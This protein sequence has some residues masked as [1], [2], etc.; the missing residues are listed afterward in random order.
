MNAGIATDLNNAVMSDNFLADSYNMMWDGTLRKIYGEKIIQTIGGYPSGGVTYAASFIEWNSTTYLVAAVLDSTTVKFY[1]S[2]V[3]GDVWSDFAQ[4]TSPST[5]TWSTGQIPKIVAFGDVLA[6]CDKTGTQ[7]PLVFYYSSGVC[8]QTIEAYDTRTRG[9]ADW[10]AGQ[11]DA[12]ETHKWLD[13]TADAQDTTATGDFALATANVTSDGFYVAGVVTFNKVIVK[14]AEQFTGSPVATYQYYQ[15]NSTWADL[16]MVTTPTWTAATGDKTIEFNIP[17]DWEQW[18]GED[19]YSGGSAVE[20]SLVGRY[21]IRVSF[22]TA[23]TNTPSADYLQVYHTQYLSLIMAGEKPKTIAVHGNRLYLGSGSAMNYSPYGSITGWEEYYVEYFDDGGAEI[24]NIVSHGTALLVL[25]PSATY[26]MLGKSY[27]DFTI[28]KLSPLGAIFNN[29]GSVSNGDYTFFLTPDR[30]VGVT[31]GSNVFNITK[32][33]YSKLADI[34]DYD[35]VGTV[36]QVYMSRGF[37]WLINAS[38]YGFV[39][40]PDTVD[41][42][43]DGDGVAAFYPVKINVR[44]MVENPFAYNDGR[45]YGMSGAVLYEMD[46][47]GV[48]DNSTSYF[49]TKD[50]D[51]DSPTTT[52]IYKRLKVRASSLVGASV[53]Q[54]PDSEPETIYTGGKVQ[55]NSITSQAVQTV[56]GDTTLGSAV[57]SNIAVATLAN[58]R[59]GDSINDTTRFYG[60]AKIIA[61]NY[62][63]GT[64][65]MNQ[66]A[67]VNSTDIAYSVYPGIKDYSMSCHYNTSGYT[68]GTKITGPSQAVPFE[69]EVLSYDLSVRR[70]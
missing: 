55:T 52:K 6:C 59:I 60:G 44:E 24:S 32:H 36:S 21:V 50:Y 57:I 47:Y 10:Y 26:A 3:S 39:V 70:F 25:K 18:D 67:R 11:Y 1:S 9:D 45:I 14:D 5:I 23:P 69:V 65:T 43:E 7:K 19:A 17:T 20:G 8:N 27:E 46:A 28:K 48:H 34:S 2:Y 68:L 61:I 56:T 16:S 42:N 30:H 22:S 41:T 63:T 12:S 29:R 51:F 54:I 64:M 4:I 58:V 38:G 49:R 66:L 40:D 13:D 31:D 53:V 37:V 33:I 62:S 15:G 35:L